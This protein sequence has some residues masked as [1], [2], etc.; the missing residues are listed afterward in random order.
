MKD[1]EAYPKEY[2][3]KTFV[4]QSFDFAVFSLNLL[5]ES[6]QPLPLVSGEG[7]CLRICVIKVF[8]GILRGYGYEKN[9]LKPN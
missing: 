5:L 6:M 7:W 8:K 9:V 2:H 4:N 3:L 1:L